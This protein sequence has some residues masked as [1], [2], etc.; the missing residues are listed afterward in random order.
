[1]TTVHDLEFQ[2]ALN[3]A[4]VAVDALKVVRD[5]GFKFDEAPDVEWSAKMSTAAVDAADTLSAATRVIN[6]ALARG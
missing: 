6:A 3:A 4:R 5:L 2:A 1:M